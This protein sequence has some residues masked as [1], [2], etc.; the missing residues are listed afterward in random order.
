MIKLAAFLS[1]AALLI[2]ELLGVRMLT[3][4]FGSSVIV[5]SA[6]IAVF[7]AAMAVGY[8]IGGYIADRAPRSMT[9]ALALWG[10]ALL[11]AACTPIA[12]PVAE[13][14]ASVKLGGYWAP[15][16]AAFVVFALPSAVLAF[17]PPIAI[18]LE[19]RDVTRSGSV[20][21]RIYAISTFGSIVGTL[22][23]PLLIS[24]MR[25]SYSLYAIAGALAVYGAL[26]FILPRGKHV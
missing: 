3:P 24:V 6:V 5:Y 12:R 18:R 11:I 7:L 26:L 14:F 15:V 2:L 9:L 1:G 10:G 13:A 20:S 4:A 25:V 22:L 23:V 16:L 17:V 19:M 8:F 21:G